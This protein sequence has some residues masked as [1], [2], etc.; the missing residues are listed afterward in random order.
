LKV[1]FP[2]KPSA[3]RAVDITGRRPTERLLDG[4]WRWQMVQQLGQSV[5]LWAF[6]ASDALDIKWACDCE[7]RR[8]QPM[9]GRRSHLVQ[10]VHRMRWQ[11]IRRA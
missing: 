11:A 10:R 9:P 8:F 4:E 3:D 5:A 7:L 6:A 1:G 2:P